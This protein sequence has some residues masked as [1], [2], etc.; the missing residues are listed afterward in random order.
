MPRWHFCLLW[1]RPRA[2]MNAGEN[3]PFQK[4]NSKPIR[5]VAISLADFDAIKAYRAPTQ[6][7]TVTYP[8]SETEH[9]KGVAA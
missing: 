9:T 1:V 2:K 5:S 7:P 4:E 3:L 6:Q 8:Q